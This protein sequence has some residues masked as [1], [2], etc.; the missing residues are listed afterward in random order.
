LRN[1]AAEVR[2]RR[3]H[4]P[5]AT[6][7]VPRWSTSTLLARPC[8]RPPTVS[9][10]AGSAAL[11][12]PKSA[13]GRCIPPRRRRPP[14]RPLA[15]RRCPVR[16]ARSAVRSWGEPIAVQS[17][18]NPAPTMVTS[19]APA[20]SGTRRRGRVGHPAASP[21]RA[22]SQNDRA[23]SPVTAVDAG[24]V[25]PGRTRHERTPIDRNSNGTRFH[26]EHHDVPLRRAT[27]Q[28]RTTSATGTAI[29]HDHER[30]D[31]AVAVRATTTHT[32][33]HSRQRHDVAG[34]ISAIALSGVTAGRRHE[35][36]NATASTTAS[37]VRSVAAESGR[38]AARGGRARGP[39]HVS[40]CPAAVP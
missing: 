22:G 32:T 29:A 20:V 28:V 35:R 24:R 36:S 3:P 21:R 13:H 8:A 33:I 4:G 7:S 23:C 26:G 6:R 2:R 11:V 19:A 15:R 17:L 40:S 16:R 10:T 9:A 18:V 5:V 39:V 37:V 31:I 25:S 12:L 14:L 27:T 34:A 38:S 1:A 30:G